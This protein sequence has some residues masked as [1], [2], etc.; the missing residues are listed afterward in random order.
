M[1]YSVQ[2]VHHPTDENEQLRYQA[3]HYTVLLKEQDT[4][5]PEFKE[6]KGMRCEVQLQTILNH[7]WSETQHDMYH[8]ATAIDNRGFGTAARQALDKRFKKIMDDYLRPA[9]YEFQKVQHDYE[10][11]MQGKTLFDR[12]AIETLESCDNN[13]ERH[14]ILSTLAEHVIP[15]Y[16]DIKCV[17]PEIRRALA[18]AVQA[19]RNT[20]TKPIETPFG[21]FSGKT[22]KDVTLAAVGIL[23]NLRYVDIEA[24]FHALIGIYKGEQNRE[25]QK[26]II[27]TI[28]HLAK[29][30]LDIWEQ[31]GPYIQAV[32]ASVIERFSQGDLP[33]LRPIVLTVWHELL[34]LEM[35]STSFSADMVTIRFDALPVFEDIKAIRNRAIEGLFALFDASSTEG[36]KRE[37]VNALQEATR[38]PGRANYSNDLLQLTLEDMQRLTE[39]L[40]QRAIG[41][42][43]ELLEHLEHGMLFD[44]WRLRQ[45]TTDE[46]S[47][48]GCKQTAEIVME[49]IITFRDLINTDQQYVRYKTLV[50]YESIF[51]FH[52]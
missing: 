37:V 32:L 23:N 43:Y 39:L 19:A 9:G 15:N 27:D 40:T 6:F 24:T 21:H 10:R 20:E 25:V 28:K 52:N 11:L 1:C 51:P 14:K 36:E 12:G 29:Y 38:L 41:Q 47:E 18:I 50:G 16:D 8:A 49:A 13:N 45:F 5:L 17:Y 30:E 22:S 26:K 33:I 44:Y 46:Y 34:G 2:R 4:T 48:S 3:I 35:E 31:A 42:P 7:A